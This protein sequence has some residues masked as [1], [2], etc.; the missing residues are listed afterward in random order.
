[1][2]TF[3]LI[4]HEPHTEKYLTKILN[5]SDRIALTRFRLSNHSLMIEKGRHLNISCVAQR[6][7]P[8]CPEEI[9]N[10]LHFLLDCKTYSQLREKLFDQ[11]HTTIINFNYPRDKQSLFRFLLSCPLI[12]HLVAK[13][14][15]HAMNVRAF[16][17]APPRNP[18]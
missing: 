13:F 6:T 5:I 15:N 10:E 18:N 16:L 2:K 12:S 11:I 8:F 9:E 14:I 7:C 17:S 1:M 3:S 4:K